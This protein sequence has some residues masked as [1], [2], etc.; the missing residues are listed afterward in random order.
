M[1]QQRLQRKAKDRY[2]VARTHR[3][4]VERL[5]PK[6]GHMGWLGKASSSLRDAHLSH[7]WSAP[8]YC[9]ELDNAWALMSVM[10]SHARSERDAAVLPDSSD[11]GST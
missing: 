2:S 6:N 8:S 4:G 11:N 3:K 10:T 7:I 9:G 1:T 5:A